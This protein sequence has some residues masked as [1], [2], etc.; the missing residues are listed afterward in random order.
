MP[1]GDNKIKNTSVKYLAKDFNDLK[2]SLIN[3][4][5]WE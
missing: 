1:Y 3:S 2:K 5:G 4:G